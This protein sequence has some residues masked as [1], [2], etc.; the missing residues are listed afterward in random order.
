[1]FKA[2]DKKAGKKIVA[3]KKVLME[4]GNEIVS[5]SLQ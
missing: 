3:L 5:A 1:V 4:D 2:R